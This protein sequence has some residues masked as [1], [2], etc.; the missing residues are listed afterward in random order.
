MLLWGCSN[1]CAGQGAPAAPSSTGIRLGDDGAFPETVELLPFD[2][3]LL[4]FAG[5][6]D[7]KN[8]Y[9][10]TVMV[11]RGD[12]LA[13]AECSGV[14][15][16]PRL[17]L[18]AGHCVCQLRMLVMPDATARTVIDGT[19]CAARASVTTVVSGT[20]RT[21]ELADLRIHTYA[22]T[23]RPHPELELILDS[24][25]AL[26]SSTAD[27][28]VIVLEEPVVPPFSGVPLA[29][30][31]AQPNEVLVMAGFGHGQ[32]A[33]EIFGARYFRKNRVTSSA[34]PSSGRFL[35]EQQGPSLHDGYKGGPCF[36]EDGQGQSLVG[37]ASIG[38]AKELSFTSIPSHRAW[39]EAELQRATCSRDP[40]PGP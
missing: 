18:T 8:R 11:T 39:V 20:V 13:G 24:Q 23:V 1:S 22:G 15:I 28:A 7:F 35:Y 33:P 21:E 32:D 9:A 29:N 38:S 12:P 2:T 19:S 30:A 37:I 25:D 36:R 10:S 4:P 27:L 3:S 31:E 5:E 26:L 14:L 6:R 34:A 40:C 17:V 16:G